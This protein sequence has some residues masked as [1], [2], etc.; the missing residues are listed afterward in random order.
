MPPPQPSPAAE[1][2]YTP[3]PSMAPG[4]ALGAVGP[5]LSGGH[6]RRGAGVALVLVTGG[7]V[8]GG[9]LGGPAG[10]FAGL[11]YVGASRNALRAH[12]LW[13]SGLTGERAEAGHSAVMAAV[14]FAIGG[15]LTY[16]AY[17]NYYGIKE[18]S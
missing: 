15:Y 10:A 17:T 8:A 7:M 13:G 6:V 4:Q 9:L 3:E 18:H 12:R 16:R 2:S 1:P 14:G 5:G 11:S